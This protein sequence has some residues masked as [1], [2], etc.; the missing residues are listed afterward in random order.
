MED[1]VGRNTRIFAIATAVWSGLALA[2]SLGLIA[3]VP[4]LLV[5]S[6]VTR[7]WWPWFSRLLTLLFM[8]LLCVVT[9]PFSFSIIGDG[10][11]YHDFNYVLMH[12]LWVVAG[13]LVIVCAIAILVD[14][15]R[16]SLVSGR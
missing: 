3:V 6:I 10:Y 14:F 12:T 9:V 4:A 7:G 15:V 5:V 16:W 2:F 11:L 1:T 8:G 13:P